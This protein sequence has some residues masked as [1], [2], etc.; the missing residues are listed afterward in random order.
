MDTSSNNEEKKEALCITHA[1]DQ[2]PEIHRVKEKMALKS[3]VC[4]TDGTLS[5]ICPIE[6]EI[7][8]MK[9]CIKIFQGKY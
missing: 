8:F 3:T 4:A 2:M 6:G 9:S 1:N 5:A 7:I